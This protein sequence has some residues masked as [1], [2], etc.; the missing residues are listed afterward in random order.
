MVSAVII[1]KN[2]ERNIKACLD[3]LKWC[4]E[5][6]VI[7]NYSS[8][9]TASLAKKSGAKVYSHKL[10]D[11]FSSLRNFGLSKAANKWVLFVDADERVSDALAEE[12]KQKTQSTNN[13]GFF[14]RRTDFLYGR[15]IKH[16][17]P[18]KIRLLRLAIKDKGLWKRRVHEYWDVERPVGLLKNPLIHMPHPTLSEYLSEI[19]KYS[20]YHAESLLEEG[21]PKNI[22]HVAFWPAFKFVYDWIFL[23]GFLDGMPGFVIA[24][25]MGLHSFLASSKLYL[26][27]RKTKHTRARARDVLIRLART[28]G[29]VTR[30]LHSRDNTRSIRYL[31]II[32]YLLLG[33]LAV[34]SFGQLSKLPSPWPEVGFYLPDILVGMVVLIYSFWLFLRKERPNKAPLLVPLAAFLGVSLLS[35]LANFGRFPMSQFF[36]GGLYFLRI[37]FYFLF[38]LCLYDYKIRYKGLASG[39]LKNSLLIV[40]LVFALFGFV[41]YLFMPNLAPLNFFGWDI[42]YYRLTSTFFDPNFAGL[43]FVFGIVICL[44]NVLSSKKRI[45]FLFLAIFYIALSLTYSRSSYLAYFVSVCVFGFRYKKISLPILALILGIATF[46]LLP[47]G[48]G[49]EGVNIGRTSTVN[50][51]LETWE[52]AWRV[53]KK[54]P[55]LGFGFDTYRY[56]RET[57]DLPNSLPSHS[58][59]SPESSLFLVMATMGVAGLVAYVFFWMRLFFLTFRSKGEN[60]IIVSAAGAG[61]FAHSLFVNSFFY[62]PI[63]GYFLLILLLA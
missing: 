25:T 19:D 46:F 47:R 27:C 60:F 42:H 17:E 45:N 9:S 33:Y 49:G 16:G 18:A 53:F 62:P 14:L 61:L 55:I 34:F 13:H 48:M 41:Q 11:D 44:S 1:A 40:S 39:L 51:R 37:T 50:A 56:A 26:K 6:V 7:D 29:A 31:G 36:V 3:S 32:D 52:E 38:Y 2:E 15:Q 20:T 57:K 8:D 28:F 12:I 24:F 59:S 43:I 63:L 5:I 35:L 23:G 54:S 30:S 10:N 58:G 21:K 4:D 22:V